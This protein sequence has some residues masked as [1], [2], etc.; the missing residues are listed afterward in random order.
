VLSEGSYYGELGF[1]AASEEYLKACSIKQV[2]VA[3]T[4]KLKQQSVLGASFKNLLGGI[5]AGSESSL[6]SKSFS[7]K[8]FRGTTIDSIPE[9]ASSATSRKSL[10]KAPVAASVL[11]KHKSENTTSSTSHGGS[12]PISEVYVQDKSF[13]TQ[14]YVDL[15]Y[16]TGEVRNFKLFLVHA[17]DGMVYFMSLDF[18]RDPLDA[19]P[20]KAGAR[21]GSNG[22]AQSVPTGA[23]GA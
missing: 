6:M 9:G 19:S 10:G 22:Q 18:Q 13:V 16:I 11:L 14:S 20:R 21:A 5:E 4:S 2:S 12:S 1:L 15:R 7:A 3:A 8:A 17:T 23:G